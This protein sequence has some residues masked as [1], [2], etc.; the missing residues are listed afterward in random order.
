[1][2]FK[3]TDKYQGRGAVRFEFSPQHF[4]VDDINKLV[5]YLGKKNRLGKYLYKILKSAWVTRIDYALDIYVMLLSDYHSGFKG[6]CCGER[7]SSEEEFE[8][9]GVGSNRSEYHVACY[10]K[11]DVG[12]DLDSLSDGDIQLIT[13]NW[14][15]IQNYRRFLRLEV[16]YK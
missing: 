2:D 12:D 1:I 13:A 16:R 6:A 15:E 5:L 3:K 10:E 11:L 8:G 9:Q 4:T 7:Y 14:R